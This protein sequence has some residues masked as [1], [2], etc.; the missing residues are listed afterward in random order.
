MGS[1]DRERK[2]SQKSSNE[3]KDPISRPSGWRVVYERKSG[4]IFPFER[5]IERAVSSRENLALIRVKGKET[6]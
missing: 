2:N 6:I 4:L 5:A 1:L 3:E